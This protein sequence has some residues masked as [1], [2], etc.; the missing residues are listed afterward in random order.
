MRNPNFPTS[1]ILLAIPLLAASLHASP[2]QSSFED[3]KGPGNGSAFF[4]FDIHR[5]TSTHLG[6]PDARSAWS[7]LGSSW[8]LEA[9]IGADGILE[10]IRDVQFFSSP[11]GSLILNGPWASMWSEDIHQTLVAWLTGTPQN[12]DSH[13]NPYCGTKDPK[14]TEVPAVPEPASMALFASGVLA[15]LLALRLRRPRA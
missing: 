8:L 13:D 7:G 2:I 12:G 10:K 5:K 6:I 3:W 9:L 4:D 11:E 1:R 14:V 15:S